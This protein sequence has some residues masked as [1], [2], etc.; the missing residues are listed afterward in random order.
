MQ[1]LPS[2]VPLPFFWTLLGI[3]WVIISSRRLSMPSESRKPTMILGTPS[4]K[5]CTQNLRSLRSNLIRSRSLF[6]SAEVFNSTQFM[7]SFGF[8]G[9]QSQTRKS[10]QI[11][12]TP[13]ACKSIWVRIRIEHQAGRRKRYQHRPRHPK[14]SSYCQCRFEQ[15]S[16][17]EHGCSQLGSLGPRCTPLK[18][19]PM[20]PGSVRASQTCNLR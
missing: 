15:Q 14:P 8:S 2:Q 9:L 3:S 7:G 16:N 13:K 20:A 10:T 18:S 17:T 1:I 5:D 6:I 4:R 12:A 19:G 11:S